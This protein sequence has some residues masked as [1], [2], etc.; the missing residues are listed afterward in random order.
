MPGYS[1]IIT[2]LL[3]FVLYFNA[4]L[5]AQTINGG[6]GSRYSVQVESLISGEII[7]RKNADLLMT[8]AS[9]LKVASTAL[10]LEVLGGDYTFTTGFYIDG[11][12]ENGTLKGDLL[13]K[14]GGDGTL[15][16]AHF[17]SGSAKQVIAHLQQKLHGAGIIHMEGS[18]WIDS[19]LFP[20][21]HYPAGRLWRIWRITMALRRPLLPGV[22]I[23][24]SCS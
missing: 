3:I 5:L 13:I 20:D 18:I 19:S 14:G 11:V 10:A 24:L 21:H 7:D 16:S 22:T 1:G 6:D 2:Q 23:L 17:S 4:S 9:T 8:P 12:I 15:G